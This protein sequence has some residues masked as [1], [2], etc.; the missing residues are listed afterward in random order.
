[1]RAQGQA[2]NWSSMGACHSS[3]R[4]G[5]EYVILQQQDEIVG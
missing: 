5:A 4:F 3:E 2:K 1:M